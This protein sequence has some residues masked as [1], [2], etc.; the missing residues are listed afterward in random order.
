MRFARA[1]AAGCLALWLAAAGAWAQAPALPPFA[2][3]EAAGARV[4][5]ISIVT[6]NV[7]DAQDPAEDNALFRLANRVHVPTRP[8]VIRRALLFRSGEPVSARLVEETERVLRAARYLH[9]VRIR[10]VAW[11]DGV[12]D[13][14]VRTRDAWSLDPGI[15]AGRSGG[16]SSSGIHVSEENLLGTGVSLGVARSRNVDRTS[17]EIRFASER[18]FGSWTAIA[19]STARSDDGGR[20]AFS[21]VRPFHALDARWTAG[22]TALRDNRIDAI[23]RAGEVESEYRHR[24]RRIEAFGGWSAGLV[25]GW[26]Q[27]WTLGASLQENAYAAEPARAA[28]PRLPADETLAGP[29]V[30]WEL[31][32]DRYDVELNRNLIGRPEDFALG[33][34]AS[35]R[36][37]WARGKSGPD[38]SA[39]LYALGLARGGEPRDG[40]TLLASATL[41]GRV[42][43]RQAER[44]RLSAQARWYVRQSRRWLFF[45][46]A[47]LDALTRPEIGDDLTLGGDNGLRGYPLRYQGGHRR[48]LFTV[49]ERYFTDLYVW[50]LFRIGA[51]AFVDTGRAWGGAQT[52]PRDA[53][54]LGNAG[55]GLRIVSARAAFGNVLHLDVAVPL[56]PA[57]DIRRVQ[58]L[59]K[60]RVSF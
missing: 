55:M 7:F 25:D 52:H 3:L 10:P 51:A 32:E 35:V 31:V 38:P 27:R 34:A 1:P 56:R 23:Y 53:G 14:E 22:V 15:S 43:D 29:F 33:L 6:Q 18:A 4:G 17:N 20:D 41:D 40:H 46:S 21:V 37:G 30:R 19:A 28:P 48:A 57:D 59:V 50:R 47:G 36:L 16:A 13:I 42:R 5:E 8:S 2:A 60:T 44:Q 11:R 26:V 39:L 49:E 24:E 58:W 45:A 12:V 9:D 54:W